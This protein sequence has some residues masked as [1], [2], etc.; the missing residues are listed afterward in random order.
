MSPARAPRFDADEVRRGVLGQYGMFAELV[1]AM[2]IEDFARPTRLGDWTVAELVGHVALGYA[3]I[4]RYFGEPSSAGKPV[5]DAIGWAISCASA[6]GEVDERARA[7]STGARPAELRVAVREGWVAVTDALREVDPGFV[8][9][10]RFGAI[11]APDYLASRCVEG[12]VHTLDLARALAV[13]PPMDAAATDVSA[14]LLAAT[15]AHQVPG[16]AVELRVPPSVAVQFG[17][18]PRHTR[19][20]PGSVVE[21]DA[22]SWLEL[23]TGRLDFAAARAGGRVQASGE[24]SDLAPY[25]PVLA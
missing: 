15:L 7:M 20:T 22:V 16:R 17:E 24:H 2:P 19:G 13:E 14:R 9:P 6:A 25:L 8:V 1:A 10:A 21:A 5:L 11:V 4:A 18:G 12:C 3:S 23:A